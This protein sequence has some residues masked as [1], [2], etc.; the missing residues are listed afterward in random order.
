[1]RKTVSSLVVALMLGWASA[2]QAG[3]YQTGLEAYD[4]GDYA[5]AL[6][7]WQDLAENGDASTQYNLGVMYSEGH[8]VAQDYVEAVKW[9]RVA[10]ESQNVVAQYALGVM[11]EEGHGVA[12][13]FVSAHMWFNIAAALGYSEAEEDRNDLE[14]EMT[15]TQIANAEKLAREWLHTH[16]LMNRWRR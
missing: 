13:D 10:A 8:G 7:E 11:H 2:A 4:A 12:A 9:W 5:T 3:D 1:M 16:A 14:L 6:R 15:S